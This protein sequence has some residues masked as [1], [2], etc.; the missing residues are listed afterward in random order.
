LLN[1]IFRKQSESFGLDIGSSSVKVVQ[2]RDRS[3]IGC[4]RKLKVPKCWP[5]A[6]TGL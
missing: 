6:M 2:I 5:A 3:L 4:S 1:K